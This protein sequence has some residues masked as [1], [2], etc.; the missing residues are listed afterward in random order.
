MSV[1][2]LGLTALSGSLRRWMACLQPDLLKRLASRDCVQA[3][4]DIFNIASAPS[5]AGQPC[6]SVC[7]AAA[8]CRQSVDQLCEVSGGAFCMSAQL[9]PVPRICSVCDLSP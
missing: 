3:L 2:A 9:C 6:P 7:L 1:V 5:P 8:A 4:D